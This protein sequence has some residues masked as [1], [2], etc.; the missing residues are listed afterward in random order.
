[1]R[2]IATWVFLAVVFVWNGLNV[3]GNL[4]EGRTIFAN[5]GAILKTIISISQSAPWWVP[6]LVLIICVAVLLCIQFDLIPQKRAELSPFTNSISR[7]GNDCVLTIGVQNV[8]E[9]T[10]FDP[11]ITLV[12]W[13]CSGERTPILLQRSTANPIVKEI[14]QQVE[15]DFSLEPIEPI[16]IVLYFAHRCRER[17]AKLREQSVRYYFKW[18]GSDASLTSATHEEREI[19]SKR[20]SEFEKGKRRSFA[21]QATGII[22]ETADNR[23][24]I[25]ILED[26]VAEAEKLE[27]FC[28]DFSEGCLPRVNTFTEV[29]RAQLRKHASDYVAAFN[30]TVRDPAPKNWFPIRNRT[31]TELAKWL[32]DKDRKT[33]W[34]IMSATVVTL[35]QIKNSLRSKL[36]L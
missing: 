5:R 25:E 24:P 34:E 10:A 35:R 9:I 12:I 32:E 23:T 17:G 27:E 36:P 3:I 31:I 1:M 29:A 20:V 4:E 14:R 30:D 2:R 16:Y 21:V 19:I 6:G 8:R 15:L 11:K 33:A 13:R 26:L 28:A 22:A 7:S 18:N